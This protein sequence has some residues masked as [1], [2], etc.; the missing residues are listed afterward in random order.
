MK[1]NSAIY[2][3]WLDILFGGIKFQLKCNSDNVF[4][5][6][7]S[8]G[9]YQY[10]LVK[11]NYQEPYLY[12]NIEIDIGDEYKDDMDELIENGGCDVALCDRINNAIGQKVL[13]H[14]LLEK[15][16]RLNI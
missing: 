5:T 11:D 16:D 4:R 10:S 1:N 3:E 9:I 13:D 6:K 12:D 7:F 2:T 15:L 8:V 14:L